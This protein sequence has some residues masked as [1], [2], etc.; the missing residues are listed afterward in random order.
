LQNKIETKKKPLPITTQT[1]LKQNI[2]FTSRATKLQVQPAEF[3]SH[4]LQ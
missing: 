4:H 3:T 1:Q 2:I